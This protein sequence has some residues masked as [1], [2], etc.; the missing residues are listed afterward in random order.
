MEVPLNGCSVYCNITS[1]DTFFFF[2]KKQ[3]LKALGLH[4]Q[5]LNYFMTDYCE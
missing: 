4:S 1:N 2:F 3:K 5:S